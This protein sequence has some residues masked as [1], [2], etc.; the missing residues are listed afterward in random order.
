MHD[1]SKNIAAS[2]SFIDALLAVKD[3]PAH[4]CEQKFLYLCIDFLNCVC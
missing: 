3:M 1:N 2:D 4:S